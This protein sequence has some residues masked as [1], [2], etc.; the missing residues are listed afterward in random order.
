MGPPWSGL[1]KPGKWARDGPFSL[2]ATGCCVEAARLEQVRT[3]LARRAVPWGCVL[4]VTF[5]AQARKVTRPLALAPVR[6][7]KPQGGRKR[8]TTVVESGFKPAPERLDL[9]KADR[10]ARC[11]ARF[12][13]RTSNGPHCA[14]ASTFLCLPKERYQSKGPPT[15][16]PFGQAMAGAAPTGPSQ[17]DVL[18][19][20]D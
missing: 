4:L 2:A 1:W 6:K 10:R 18:S 7:A 19:R 15:E 14:R 16:A 20:W 13:Q 11:F 5:L 9:S 3:W 8:A 17:R 12:K